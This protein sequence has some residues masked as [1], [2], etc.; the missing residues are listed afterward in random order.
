MAAPSLAVFQTGGA[1]VTGDNLNSMV[2]SCDTMSEL[3]ALVGVAGMQIFVRGQSAPNDG[4]QGNFY[5]NVNGTAPDDNG[6][7]TVVPYGAGSGEW[8]RI[9]NLSPRGT[10]ATTYPPNPS[11]TTSLIGVMMGLGMTF[12]PTKSGNFLLMATAIIYNATSVDGVTAELRYGIGTAPSNGTPLAGTNIC[13]AGENNIPAAT[14]STP[15]ALIAFVGNLTVGVTYWL[16]LSLA[17]IAG[18]TANAINVT[19]TVVEL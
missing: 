13:V 16:D 4:L 2:Q 11:G 7:T 9:I 3:R 12:T 10:L 18:G 8:T 15:V 6:V 19:L 14:A 5:W 1:A 17:A